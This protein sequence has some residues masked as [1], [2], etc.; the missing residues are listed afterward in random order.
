ME[1]T[2]RKLAD[3]LDKLEYEC[4]R[5]TLEKEVGA[6]I[7]DSRKVAPGCLFICISGANFD[8][9]EFAARRW[10]RAQTFW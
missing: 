6:V 8:G 4:V 10:K 1:I 7:Y 3:L 5:G 9:H 2:S